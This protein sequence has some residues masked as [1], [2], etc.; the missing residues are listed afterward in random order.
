[1]AKK[2]SVAKES[3][4]HRLHYNYALTGKLEKLPKTESTIHPKPY[5]KGGKVRS[6]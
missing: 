3:K 6:K 1:M 5:A 2:D 4:K